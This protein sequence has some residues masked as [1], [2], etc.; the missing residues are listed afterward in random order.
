MDTVKMT[1]ESTI[2]ARAIF[3]SI[4]NFCA[5]S[6]HIMK[7]QN[8]RRNMKIQRNLSV[9]GP[10]LF[11]IVSFLSRIFSTRLFSLPPSQSRIVDSSTH[12]RVHLNEER[13]CLCVCVWICDEWISSHLYHFGAEREMLSVHKI[14]T[15]CLLR[16][17]KSDRKK[18]FRFVSFFLVHFYCEYFS[19]ANPLTNTNTS[20]F[21][22]SFFFRCV[23]FSV[24]ACEISFL[25]ATIKS[26]GINIVYSCS[27]EQFR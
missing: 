1:S 25:L 10:F 5:D 14:S 19:F 2:R 4:A 12:T 18:W 7:C 8:W 17:R 6:H 3:F 20:C 26:A 27:V 23:M 21:S 13:V 11:F 22:H 24:C 16:H 9:S 15:H